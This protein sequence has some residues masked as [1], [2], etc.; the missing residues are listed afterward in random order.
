MSVGQKHFTNLAIGGHYTPNI[1][2]PCCL[3]FLTVWCCQPELPGSG[4]ISKTVCRQ[5]RS[6]MSTKPTFKLF[7]LPTGLFLASFF[8]PLPTV[9]QLLVNINFGARAAD[10]KVGLAATGLGTNDFWNPYS[11]YE[12]KF[13]PGMP[14][15]SNGILDRLK[16]ADGSS[17]A[18]AVAVTNAPGVWGNST[19]DPM[20]DTYIFSQNSSNIT[21]AVSGL[22][23]GR[24]QF[25]FYGHADADVSGEQNSVF[26]LRAGTNSFG[27]LAQ[28]G[29]S[30]WKAGAPWQERLHYAVFRDVPVDTD[31]V[32]IQ[33]APGPNGIAV[34]NGMQIISR[35][36]SPPRLLAVSAPSLPP[37]T[38]NLL[39]REIRYEG[40]VSD[41]EARFAVSLT[42]ESLTTNEI[43]APLFEG[44]LALASPVLPSGLRIVRSGPQTRLFCSAPGIYSLKLDVI[45]R[46]TRAEPWNQISF[47]GPPAAI[48]SVSAAATTAGVELQLLSG[49][50]T[51]RGT[52]TAGN[53]PG[54]SSGSPSQIEGLLGADRTLAMRWQSRGAEV[55]RKSLLTVDTTASV[56]VSPTVVKVTSTL[57]YEIL[58]APIS[59]LSIELPPNQALTRIQGEQ[60]RDWQV[61]NEGARQLLLVE[62]I[63]PVEKTCTLKLFSEQ[64]LEATPITATLLVPQP[65]DVGRESGS[66]TLGADDTTVEVQAAPGLW[67][68]N[69]PAD[70][71]AAYRFNGR[72]VSVVARLRRIEPV[73]TVTDRATARVEETRVLLSHA[74]DLKVEKAG[75][76]ALDATS[77][78]GFTVTEVKGDGIDDWK[79]VEGNLRISFSS[80][81]LGQRKIIVQLEQAH[82][83]FPEQVTVQPLLI[84]GA[85]NVS[86]L[87]GASS[88]PGIRLKSAALS[89]LREVPI[90]SLTQR[91]DESLAFASEQP[92]WSLSL[93]TE[94]LSPRVVAEVFNLVTI[95]DGQVG[96]SATIRY[97]IVNQGV[98]EFRIAVPSHWKN[99]DFT[100]ANIRRKEQRTNVWTI[101]LQD[102]AWGGYTLVLTYDYQFDPKGATLDLAGAHAIDVERETG[103]LGLMTAAS[104]RLIPAQ[105]SDSLR[106][107]DEAE[108]SQ[109][110]RALCTRPLLLAYKYTGG[111]YRHSVEVTRFEE[112]SVLEAVAD[113]IELTSVLT[114]EGQ[115]LTQS[116]FMVKNNEKQFQK[117]KLPQG[118]EFWSSFVN[119][120]PAKPERDGDWFLV[121]LPRD[122]NRDQAFAVDIVFAQKIDVKSS[123]VPRRV[124]LAA[125]LTDIPS[126]YAEWQLFAPATQRLSR[127][128]GSMT[129]ASGTTYGLHE[130]WQ[131]FL[132][133]Y[134]N[135]IEHHSGAILFCFIV[136]L[137]LFLIGAALRRGAK[138]ALQVIAVFAIMGILAAMLLPAL[139]RAKSK[140]Q[141]ISA[142]NNLK[143]IGL[144]AKTWSADNG[145]AFPATLEAMKNELGTDKVLVDPNTGQRFVY[146]GTGKTEA[147]PEAILA[148]SPS[149]QN[150]RAVLF[151]DG[152]V[153]IL[154]Q[155]KFDQAMQ[156][157]AA[158][159][160]TVV[161]NAPAIASEG[162]MNIPRP[163]AAV[164]DST[165]AVPALQAP[166]AA[167][168]PQEKITTTGVR[169]IRIEIPRAGQ[170]FT[171]TKVLNSG[172]EPLRVSASMMRLKVYRTM[173]M[174]LQVCA[175]GLGLVLFSVLWIRASRNSFWMAV[176]AAL[177]L[178]SVAS[179]LT[180]W[181]ALH[182]GFII[183][184][185]AILLALVSWIGWKIWQRRRAARAAKAPPQPP[186]VPSTPDT[187]VLLTLL[188]LLTSLAVS[189]AQAAVGALS[190]AVSILSANYSGSAS[191]KVAQLEAVMQISTWATNQTVPLF[192]DDI[193][194]QSFTAEGGATLVRE[195]YGIGVLVPAPTAALSLKFKLVAK[196][197]GEVGRRQLAF[198]IPP[199]LAST[200]SI[201]IDETEVDVEFPAA[202]AFESRSTNQQTRVTAV[203]GPSDRL[204]MNWTPR[205]KRA[206]EIAA[207]VFVHNASLI[208]IGGGVLNSRAT[209][210]YQISQ[211]ELKQ[212]RVQ[213]P[214]DHRV[215]RVEG[216]SLRMWE[217]KDNIL[218]VDLLKG[219]SSAY[220]LTLETE[221]VLEKLPATVQVEISHA[222]DVK[223]ETGLLGLRGSEELTLGIEEVREL[224][225][226]DA[227]E[228]AKVQPDA[229]ISTTGIISAFRFLKAGFLLTA[230]AETVQSQLE[231]FVRNQMRIGSESVQLDAQIEYTIK[232]AGLFTLRLALPAGYRLES[233]VGTNISQWVEHN[234]NGVNILE[235]A[236][237][238][239][240]IG[241]YALG[242]VLA[243][244]YRQLPDALPILGVHP[245][246]TEKLSGVVVVSTEHGIA[247]KT[248][249]LNGLTEIPYASA[250]PITN[251][252]SPARLQSSAL[253][254]KFI[255]ATP[256]ATPAWTLAVVTEAVE[257][258]VRAEILNTVTVSESLVSGRTLVKYD[259]ANAPIKEFRLRVPSSFKNVDISAPQIRRRD[260]TNDEW[261]VELQGKV[262]GE[263]LLTITW[264]FPTSAETNLIRLSGVQALGVERESG[265][266]V[267]VARPPLQLAEKAATE[268]L[269][270][271]DVRELPEWGG[272]AD[273]ATVLAYRY[274]RPG[275]A[276][277]VEARRFQ[278]AEVLQ[279]LIDSV[280]LTTVVADDG[281]VMTAMALNVRNNGRQH[282][283][284]ELPAGSIV[285]SA[286][287]GSDPVR[288][289]KR[290]GKFLLPLTREV[291]SEAP[292][293][294]ELTYIGNDS[295]PTHRGTLSLFSPRFDVPLKN[296]RWDLYLPPD[297]EYSRFAGS[298]SR[299][300]D[301]D[302]PML[303][304]FSLSE[305]KQQ[306]LAQEQEQTMK[307]R[308]GLKEA[309]DNLSGG[310]LREALGSFNRAKSRGQQIS[311]A[312][313]RDKD[314][315]EVQQ[316]L[317]RAQSSNLIAAQ[318]NYFVENVGKLADQRALQVQAPQIFAN[319]PGQQ[320][321][322]QGG[323]AET[324]FLN[325]D[326]E[327]AGLQWDKLEKAQQV[328]AAKVAPLR[329]NLPTRGVHYSFSQVLQTEP[330][331][332]MTVR[333][334]ADSTKTPSWSIRILLSATGFLVLWLVMV[335]INHQRKT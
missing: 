230:R 259:I 215:L 327:V 13:S 275:Y 184:V 139:S 145:N 270:R 63:K 161:I 295:F 150:G 255:T 226:V 92:V 76:Y 223:R 191:E 224:Q 162:A 113:R 2:G 148:Y 24:Y 29:G 208:T 212:V 285:W 334:H 14:L 294:V 238:G 319:V 169:P 102:K 302:I 262:R 32:V 312:G 154:N 34:L 42:V 141:R 284:I 235:V 231:A 54:G 115:L 140:A 190:N 56:L 261:R 292:V 245:L 265:F 193:A 93:S 278:E 219:V 12:P 3:D 153:Q 156:R 18:I 277:D 311:Q 46:I 293:T 80:R 57:R 127:F 316:Q 65:L 329:V 229:P 328:A 83:E 100:G 242:C 228:F 307:L 323:R 149:D 315:Q 64:T 187:F 26:T 110:D 186:F 330:R 31:P 308:Y 195:T 247:A 239:R 17:S 109:N 10:T 21:V 209:F 221:R 101:F 43:S 257:P 216:E 194:V 279:A 96:G 192:G 201:V 132:G 248:A 263:F 86:T 81:V 143:Q 290:D 107:V 188:A 306:E 50:Q 90:N 218:L 331:K 174:I 35:G 123:L 237:K 211:G 114:E 62:F 199:A 61:K 202:V 58:Q 304:S 152:S 313:E 108:L 37:A 11:H 19:A 155:E 335:L 310:N 180:M 9:A 258:W 303:Q 325:N 134:G 164:L 246:A 20:F 147:N 48:S 269:S 280:R 78:S 66:I 168:P 173:H 256:S 320:I 264:E 97:G 332:P 47:T 88:S 71:L 69:A 249:S 7:L 260:Q 98:Q 251:Q 170:A 178:A 99:L 300:S 122:A 138:G 104:L 204:E 52:T 146:V 72:P 252:E 298:M 227:E 326:V 25:Y 220:R 94:K 45:A 288:P 82:P 177:V 283:E 171:F 111:A 167:A 214:R 131:Q 217:V 5:P 317:R 241:T 159:P 266:L 163:Q 176:A 181:R 70:A 179:L 322:A 128:K 282:L 44:D 318:N 87:L 95:G 236:L 157:D 4:T 51:I 89:S 207:T 22:A 200:V 40:K 6:L 197:G 33:V 60:I 276:L 121:P 225:R 291:A 243:Q 268:L 39:F 305:Y 117:F 165:V 158:V 183:T 142:V 79:A 68:V 324:L 333:L 272:R 182:F 135:L 77:Q 286:F 289:S 210:D 105:L 84:A 129:V 309:R 120:Q 172:S 126:T 254:Y 15:V 151:A 1:Q 175:F 222:L 203:I 250:F 67:Q 166:A 41:A 240:T 49:T 30:S 124:E 233:V 75:I 206:A 296:A 137:V 73:I 267:L 271:I 125:P 136:G 118:A 253:A 297:Y 299:S 74:L 273:S 234:D 119:G 314:L 198:A 59:R 53:A 23:P 27:P 116:S 232:R 106:R 55:A 36:T 196:L 28:I 144:A 16:L 287:V 205:I 133:F 213:I 91:S 8:V 274:L 130:A 301:A 185:P 112:V 321:T 189:P 244:N 103:S 281:Q 38:T 85:T 160:R